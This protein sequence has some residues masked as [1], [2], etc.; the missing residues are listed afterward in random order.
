M[1]ALRAS[2]YLDATAA[3]LVRGKKAL[4]SLETVLSQACVFSLP[5][6]GSKTGDRRFGS[7][8]GQVVWCVLKVLPR[9][10]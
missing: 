4:G 10:K 7:R 8:S 9:W 5:R 6:G 1:D 3:S 2:F